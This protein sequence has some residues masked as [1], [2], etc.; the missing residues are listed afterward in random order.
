VRGRLF[1]VA[2]GT[3][4]G[5]L[6]IFSTLFYDH[7]GDSFTLLVL[8]FCGGSLLFVGIALARG[9]PRPG[10]RDAGLAVLLGPAQ[11]AATFCLFV[12]FEHAS[13]GLVVLLFYVY[14]LLVT[15]GAGAIFG[16]ELGRRRAALLGVGMAG[17]ALTVGLPQSTSGL[18]IVC[19][20]S[21]GVF[22]AVFI[23]GS[24]HVMLRGV[25]AFQFVA[26]A[27]GGSAV[28]MLAAALVRGLGHT[29]G[30]ALTYALLVVVAGTVVP[31][32]FFYSAIRLIG[33]GSATRLATIEPL[34]AVVLSF[35]VLGD[36][37]TAGQIAG[38]AL[39][40]TSVVALAASPGTLRSS[41][42]LRAAEP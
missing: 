37:L 10:W 36:S 20:L 27:Y 6:G 34:T 38:G 8:R 39:V 4:Y 25:D 3:T 16:E 29:S 21:A 40:L 30:P 9:R 2:A 26:L 42:P 19:G 18:G 5:T 35:L 31:A 41:A 14:P 7:G 12:G 32:L 1:A 22:T 13:P 33:A 28:A 17:I 11:L 24:R 23:L 15:I